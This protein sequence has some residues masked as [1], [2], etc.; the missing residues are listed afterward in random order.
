MY[1]YCWDHELMDKVPNRK[2]WSAI[3]RVLIETGSN[4][5]LLSVTRYELSV[6]V[7]RLH[8]YTASP[9][10]YTILYINK[11]SSYLNPSLAVKAWSAGFLNTIF[12]I[13]NYSISL[14]SSSLADKSYLNC[15][16]HLVLQQLDWQVIKFNRAYK[17]LHICELHSH[18]LWDQCSQNSFNNSFNTL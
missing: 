8:R 6:Q 2:R 1:K 7:H 15:Q 10:G 18:L 9:A 12:C 16:H 5:R 4:L 11:P 3:N 17:N 14:L 13:S